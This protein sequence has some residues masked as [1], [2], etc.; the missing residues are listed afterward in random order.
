[1]N[2]ELVSIIMPA[3]NAE[4]TIK[5]SIESILNQTIKDFRIYIIDDNSIDTTSKIIHSFNDERIIYIQNNN[6][7]GVSKSRNIGIKKCKGKYIAFLD[8]DD[9][10]FSNKLEKQLELLE[11]GWD[12]VCSNYITFTENNNLNRRLSPEIISYEKM[13][14]SNFIGNLTGIYN[15]SSLGK[16]YQKEKGHEDYIMWLEILKI[17]NKAYCIQEPLA[18]YRVSDTSLSGNKLKAI[19]WQWSIYRDELNLSLIKSSYYFINYIF[20]ALKKRK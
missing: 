19:Q 14:L 8:S 17:T 16:F 15:S 12:V 20:N 1:M 18:K 5:S 9:Q 11:N 2:N 3:F 6:N 4:K 10:W 7:Q 13:L